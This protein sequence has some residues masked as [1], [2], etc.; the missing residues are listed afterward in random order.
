MNLGEL[1]HHLGATLSNPEVAS[2]HISGVAT[3]EEATS[4]QVTFLSNPKYISKLDHCQAGAILVPEMFTTSASI[5]LLKV[6]HPYLAF[7]KAIEI[8]YPA[9][10][11]NQKI[12]PTAV[13]G[14][15]VKLGQGVTIGAYVVIGDRV[16]LGDRVTIHPHCVIYDDAVL[17]NDCLLH[18]HV[19]LRERVQLGDRVILQNGVILGADGYG[20]VPMPDGSH[21]KIPQVGTVVVED[22]V[23]IQA[24]STVDRATLTETRIGA[25]SKIDNLVMVAHNCTIGKKV[26][27]CAQV[28]LAGS[29]QVGNN[30][31]LAGQVGA[32]GHLTIGDRSIAS[33][34]TGINNSLPPDSQVG[35]YPN[36]DQKL[37]LRVTAA[38]KQLPQLLRRFRHLETQVEHLTAQHENQNPNSPL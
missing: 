4:K 22:D 19:T 31:I 17:G 13:L 1:A 14:E 27:L 5:P 25:G 20:F 7:A 8:F 38:V 2:V 21:Y 3:I 23:E 36:M 6:A 35:G 11:P 30:V 16:V 34:K 12:H 29:T 26:I 15:G 32:A 24:L 33:A 28:G 9:T 10:P 37:F 18:S